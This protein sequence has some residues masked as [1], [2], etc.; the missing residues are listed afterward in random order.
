LHSQGK[1][2]EAIP[3]LD[4]AISLNTNNTDAYNNNVKTTTAKLSNF[5][6]YNKIKD[7]LDSITDF[8]N[9]TKNYNNTEA[10]NTTGLGE[11]ESVPL[12]GNSSYFLEGLA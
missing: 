8:A 1:N 5:T 4:K 2:A 12:H 3:V 9:N 11:V 10:Y 6:N 7:L